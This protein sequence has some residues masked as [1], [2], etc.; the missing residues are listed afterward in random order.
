LYDDFKNDRQYEEMKLNENSGIK[1]I[2]KTKIEF[3]EYFIKTKI[4]NQTKVI[5]CS[6]YFKIFNIMKKILNQHK[7]SYIELDDGNIEDIN[8]SIKEYKFGNTNILLSNSNFFGCGLNLECTSDIVFLHK[9]DPTLEKQIIGRAQ[10]FGRIH[11]LNIWYI[12]HENES[13]IKQAKT[14]NFENIQL[15]NNNEISFDPVYL[16]E[17][18]D[19]TII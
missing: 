4:K 6:N 3:I 12:M 13:I 14:L 1:Y 16:Q 7:L 19:Y 15:E 5:F 18:S 8:N 2:K 9:T 10:R 11:K 17:S